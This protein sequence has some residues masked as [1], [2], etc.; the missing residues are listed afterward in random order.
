MPRQRKQPKLAR[1]SMTKHMDDATTTNLDMWWT[2][3]GDH[4][5]YEAPS[6][7]VQLD[8]FSENVT[9]TYY[10]RRIIGRRQRDEV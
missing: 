8:L 6:V 1:L 7:L 10:A 2:K 4:F 5:E 3:W 9:I